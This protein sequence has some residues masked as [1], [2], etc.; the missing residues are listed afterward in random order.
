MA[1]TYCRQLLS[2]LV[3]LILLLVN[4]KLE[5]IVIMEHKIFAGIFTVLGIASFSMSGFNGSESIA[6]WAM[7]ILANIHACRN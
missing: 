6:G 4:L 5:G 7:I 2:V 3:L 1:M